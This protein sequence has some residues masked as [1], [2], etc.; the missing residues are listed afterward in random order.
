M[1]TFK[2]FGGINYSGQQNI[3]NATYSTTDNHRILTASG[4]TNTRI[5]TDSHIDMSGKSLLRVDGIYFNDGTIQRSA[6][7]ATT[8]P[9][10]SNIRIQSLTTPQTTTTVGLAGPPGPAG[11]AG[12]PGKDG[13]NTSLVSDTRSNTVCGTN[14]L[15]VGGAHAKYNSAFGER[16]LLK[17]STGFANS[18]FGY[19]TLVNST[20]GSFNTAVG[21]QALALN[22]TGSRLTAIGAGADTDHASIQNSTAIGAGAR[23]STSNTV[24]L[25]NTNTQHV[26]TSGVITGKAKN[27]TIPH[28]VEG[29]EKYLVLKH[30]SVE[31]PR[32]DLIYR[33]TVNLLNGRILVNL[34]TH[35]SMTEGT[36][37]ALC[38]NPSVFV[39]NESDWD[40]VKGSVVGN[41]LSIES[42]NPEACSRVAF[43]VVAER[44]DPGIVTSDI[45]DEKGNF[46]PERPVGFNA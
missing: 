2:Q 46:V 1:P 31:A 32:L 7:T 5:I 12:P 18:G 23:V 14:S 44:T 36:F 42:R 3:T 30:A 15:L 28:P 39:S 20:S 19:E 35:F 45:T 22:I 27:F 16:V 4:D 34:D 40:Q 29:L 24:V 41:L 11:P 9:P 25:G 43:M 6:G 10:A 38:K 13:T 8:A 17:N 33:D 21:S 26:I 37:V